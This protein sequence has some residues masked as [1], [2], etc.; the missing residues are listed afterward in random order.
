[1]NI[2][3]RVSSVGKS[4]VFLESV[5]EVNVKRSFVIPKWDNT[6]VVVKALKKL[7]AVNHLIAVH[8]MKFVTVTVL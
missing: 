6:Y 5:K 4:V 7:F 1:M 3:L 2:V 8:L